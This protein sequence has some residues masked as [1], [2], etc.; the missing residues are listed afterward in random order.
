MKYYRLYRIDGAGRITAAEWI[1]ATDDNSASEQASSLCGDGASVELWERQ[2]LVARFD[3]A[4]RT[5]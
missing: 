5:G 1:E 4:R 2:R 3:S